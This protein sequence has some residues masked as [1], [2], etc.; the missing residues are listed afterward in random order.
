M[1]VAGIEEQLRLLG[2]IA[3]S[4]PASTSPSP[5]KIGFA[6]I[7]WICTGTSAG[8]APNSEAGKHE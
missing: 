3:S 6:Y 5:T 2:G 4:R 8:D 1:L 7:P